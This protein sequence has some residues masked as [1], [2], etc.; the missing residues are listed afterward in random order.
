[1]YFCFNLKK[2]VLWSTQADW[3][4]RENRWLSD[5]LSFSCG[6]C[7]S[8]LQIY[9]RKTNC[10]L[11]QVHGIGVVQDP[12][13]STPWSAR[14]LICLTCHM[15][16]LSLIRIHLLEHQGLITQPWVVP[17]WNQWWK[18]VW[19]LCA[20]HSSKESNR[21][22]NLLFD[23][24]TWSVL[25]IMCSTFKLKISGDFLAFSCFFPAISTVCC[26]EDGLS[27]F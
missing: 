13:Q 19:Q 2:S 4:T 24:F 18:M 10:S 12:W 17:N 22:S 3:Q 9:C 1:M 20:L 5:S 8:S 26:N 25:F 7:R 21:A 11:W 14:W 27:Y 16:T 23:I 6:W 15:V